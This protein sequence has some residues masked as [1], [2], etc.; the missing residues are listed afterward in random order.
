MVLEWE[1][2]NGDNG[3]CLF[4]KMFAVSPPK[5][6]R[7]GRRCATVLKVRH[8]EFEKVEVE[9]LVSQNI[10]DIFN[11]GGGSCFIQECRK[12]AKEVSSSSAREE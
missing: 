4:R 1:S 11:L 6:G 2:E 5:F 3:K 7:A 8:F 10:D 12:T 9:I